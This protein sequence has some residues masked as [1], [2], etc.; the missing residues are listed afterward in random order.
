MKLVHYDEVESEE[1]DVAC[2]RGVK[3][4]W[5]ISQ[6]DDP[7]NFY[8]RRYELVPGGRTP[9]HAHPWEHEVYILE[10][11]GTVLGEGGTRRFQAGDVLYVPPEEEHYFA[12]D[13]GQSTAFLCLV[14]K[15]GKPQ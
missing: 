10:G 5:L 9:R 12:A 13:Q 1:V 3:V 6:E 15:K 7:P 11:A 8:M 4:R 2:A 14:P